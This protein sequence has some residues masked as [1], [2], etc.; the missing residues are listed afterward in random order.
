MPSASP[1]NAAPLYRI[2]ADLFKSLGHPTRIRVLEVLSAAPDHAAGVSEL[3]DRVGVEPSQLSQHL[4]VLKSARVVTSVRTGNAVVYRLSQPLVAELLV[5]ARA[6]LRSS[7]SD[8]S[9]QLTVADDLP[10]LSPAST[11]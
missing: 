10:P 7:L 11:P 6:F 1:D 2:K 9:S 5:V 3:L 4:A 8:A